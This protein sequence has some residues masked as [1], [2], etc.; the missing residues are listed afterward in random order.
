MCGVNSIKHN[1]YI[2]INTEK[3]ETF[4][5]F[6]FMK[7]LHIIDSGGLY[8]AEMMLLNLAYQ[9]NRMR[10]QAE[11]ASIGEKR[12]IKKPLEK[13]ARQRGIKVHKFRMHPGPNLTGALKIARFSRKHRFD[14]LHSHGYKANILL[15]PL[16]KS[17]RPPMITTIHGYTSVKTLSKIKLYEWLD[18]ICLNV[19]DAVVLVN[20]GMLLHPAFRNKRFKTFVVNNGISQ[21]PSFFPLSTS[22]KT[23]MIINEFCKGYFVIASIGRLSPEKG[24][25]Y[26][27]DA[28]SVLRE[29]YQKVR[30]LLIGE[31]E[32]R[33]IL[34]NRIR[35]LHLED[36]VLMTG[37]LPDATCYLSEIKVLA[38]PSLTEGLPITILEA[39]RGEVPIV[40]SKVGGIPY[41][42]TDRK[43]ALLV[44][45][46]NPGALVRAVALFYEQP[47]LR[48]ALAA[49]ANRSFKQK[50]SSQKMAEGYRLI[51]EK[52]I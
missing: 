8:G 44:P 16:P 45:P 9:Q 17:I 37:Y 11:I 18:R 26:L 30:L 15:G 12:I 22:S 24:I 47:D 43:S 33:Q 28:F 3:K 32:Q 14:I 20:K 34:E 31:G 29:K 2:K 13:E 51:Y 39:M 52:I 21:K 4:Y 7:I 40:A 48:V 42:L 5:P 6:D 36:H 46:A 1:R 23:D 27:I 50:Y 49:N 10:L 19:L 41:V 25:L 35:Q 38:L